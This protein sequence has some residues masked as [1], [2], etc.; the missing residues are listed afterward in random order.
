MCKVLFGYSAVKII[1]E[2]KANG[3]C[4]SKTIKNMHLWHFMYLYALIE[5]KIY[6]I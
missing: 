3:I 5:E 4:C 1:K 2:F 6:K